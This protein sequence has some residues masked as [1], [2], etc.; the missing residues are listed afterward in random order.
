M[1][2][3]RQF[4]FTWN[5]WTEDTVGVLTELKCKY[6]LYGKEVASTGTRHLQ[7]VV[8]YK[9]ALTASAARKRMKGA[10]VVVCKGT[11]EQN[12]TY[13]KKDGDWIERG[14][15]PM[16]QK[17]KGEANSE[18]WDDARAAAERGDWDAI[19]SELWIKYQ[20]SLRKMQKQNVPEPLEIG[21]EEVNEWI[22]GPAG[23]G[24]ST[25][26]AAENPGAFYKG[27]NKWWDGF[28]DQT[29]VIVD[30]MDPFHKSLS[31][32]FKMWGQHQPFNAEVKGGSCC[33]RPKKIV[34]TSNYSIDEI[35]EDQTTRDAMHRRY[36]EIY[37]PG[38]KV[39][40][41]FVPGFNPKN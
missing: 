35:W 4:C 38:D 7:G 26:A 5:N 22:Y 40:P 9:E 19:P 41:P 8:V 39:Y 33:L 6:L 34:I 32:E 13:C 3:S 11:L 29:T 28:T 31:R 27:C 17:E 15:K 12:E 14:I 23:T 21:G 25:R 24:K 18:R 10:H 2:R 20:N 36:K 1:E 16:T 30:D 37:M